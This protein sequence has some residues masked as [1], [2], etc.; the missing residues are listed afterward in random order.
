MRETGR[1]ISKLQPERRPWNSCCDQHCIPWDMLKKWHLFFQ[2]EKQNEEES[3]FEAENQTSSFEGGP[4]G[5]ASP[6]LPK[7]PI[8]FGFLKFNAVRFRFARTCRYPNI[9]QLKVKWLDWRN[10]PKTIGTENK[11][12]SL[13]KCA[14][15][16]IDYRK[17]IDGL[18]LSSSEINRYEKLEGFYFS[19]C[20]KCL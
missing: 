13:N 16:L 10:K 17:R 18:F 12:K 6:N 5:M 11:I 9:F 19:P 15:S 1:C 2:S 7:A 3:R 20:T 8:S 4:R 14:Q